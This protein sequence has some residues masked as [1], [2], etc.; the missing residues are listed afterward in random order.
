M[1]IGLVGEYNGG[2]LGEPLLFDCCEYAIKEIDSAYQVEKIDLF[3][4]SI[5]KNEIIESKGVPVLYFGVRV[6]RKI[7]KSLG[8]SHIMLDEW[9]WKLSREE[10][11]LKDFFYKK[12]SKEK[13][14]GIIIMGAGTLKY[15]VRLNFAPYYKVVIDTA[16]T[17]NIP[18][19]VNCVGVE[20]KYNENDRR[21]LQFSECLSNDI[22]KMITTRDDI[23][24]LNKFVKNPSIK[25]WKIADIGVWAA[26]TFGITKQQET[27]YIGLG[28]ITPERFREFGRMDTYEKYEKVWLEIIEELEQKNKKWKIFNNGDTCDWEFAEKICKQVGKSPEEYV[29]TPTNPRELVQIVSG[30]KGII[31]SRLHSCI[32]AYSL[33]IPFVAISWNNKLRYFA[34][35]IQVPERIT[36]SDELEKDLILN[37]FENALEQGYNNTYREEFRKTSK[38]AMKKYIISMKE[39]K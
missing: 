24:T 20:S 5:K 31:T 22:V 27:D 33:E 15:D 26:E 28:M 13:Y 9:V 30:F 1:K 18:V 38:E 36:E 23:D 37:K 6:L 25:T 4:R 21:C 10:K 19:Y 3:G 14:D 17:L 12:M 2:N 34:Q 39:G 35:E 8:F 29:L 11:R 7:V 16:N 32:V